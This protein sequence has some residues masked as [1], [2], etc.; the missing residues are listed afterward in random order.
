MLLIFVLLVTFILHHLWTKRDLYRLSWQMPGP[1]VI[2]FIGSWI[3][4]LGLSNDGAFKIVKYLTA[5]YQSPTKFW[6][7]SKLFVFISK[8]KDVQ[9]FLNSPQCLNRFDFNI[10]APQTVAVGLL[11]IPE[12]HW[13]IHRKLINPTF[14]LK[15]LQSYMPIFNRQV[16]VLVSRLE[17]LDGKNETDM[18]PYMSALTLDAVCGTTMG[19]EMNIQMDQNVEYISA[20]NNVLTIIGETINNPIIYLKWLFRIISLAEMNS[21]N[22]EVISKFYKKIIENKRESFILRK[23]NGDTDLSTP[24][25]KLFIDHLMNLVVVEKKLTDCDLTNEVN[26]IINAAFETTALTSS[27][28]ILAMAMFPE[29]QKRIY[30]EIKS[31]M[32]DKDDDI[33]YDDLNKYEFLDRFI[34]E[35]LRLFTPAP[36]M[37]RTTSGT[38][39]L[40][41]YTIPEGT[42]ISCPIG[43][44]HRKKEIWGPTAEEFD[45]DRFLPENFK[46]IPPYAYLPFGGGPRNCIGYKY[47]QILLTIILVKLVSNFTFETNLR[48]ED[49][50]FRMEITTKLVN[51]HMVYVKERK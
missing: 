5:N 39:K 34:K 43:I 17:E 22:F 35:C 45:P 9:V 32:L 18:Y 42:I 11:T 36:I 27:Y 26:S 28:C 10:F 12:P 24:P 19:Y 30:E 33:Q 50:R 14:S 15:T 16:N 38:F 29:Q 6:L 25:T 41:E 48:M 3:S 7:G 4:I 8:P 20:I 1:F 13:K 31:I 44:I 46:Q 2:P 40:G 23:L 21:K 37:T 51:K 49:L 47:A